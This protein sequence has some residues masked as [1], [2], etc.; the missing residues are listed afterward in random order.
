MYQGET[1]TTVISGFPIPI[2]EIANIYIIFRNGL[3][4]LLEKTLKDCEVS[5][6]NLTFRLTQ[7]ESLSLSKGQIMRSVIIITKDGSRIESD[8][9]PFDCRS[10]V[11]N[12]VLT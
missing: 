7:Q 8:P 10:T 1:I 12:E 2:S 5:G 11:K 3:R 6:V 9:S 4:I